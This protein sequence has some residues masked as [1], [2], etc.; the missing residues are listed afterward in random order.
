M[1]VSVVRGN[2]ERAALLGDYLRADGA[3]PYTYASLLA[4]IYRRGHVWRFRA[5][6]QGYDHGLAGLARDY[7]VD[8]AG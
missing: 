2:R 3:C 5:V 7:G 1:A 6:G 4:E 8:I